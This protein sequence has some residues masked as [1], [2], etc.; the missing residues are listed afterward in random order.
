MPTMQQSLR[1][2]G[3]VAIV[4]GASRSVL[5]VVASKALAETCA[6]L[7]CSERRLATVEQTAARRPERPARGR[8]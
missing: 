6:E 4:A 2:G 7:V 5:D 3:R 1:L 8:S